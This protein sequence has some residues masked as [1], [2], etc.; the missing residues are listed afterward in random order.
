MSNV[1]EVIV[2]IEVILVCIG[3]VVFV[4][5]YMT[6][7]N[8][9]KT[10]AG[11]SLLYFV[12][13]LLSLVS[14]SMIRVLLSNE[15]PLF[16]ISRGLVYT[17]LLFTTW[18][19]VKVL[20]TSYKTKASIGYP[21][22]IPKNSKENILAEHELEG[23]HTAHVEKIWYQGQRVIRSILVAAPTTL[24][25][26]NLSLP[27]LASAFNSPDVPAEVYVLVN[28]IVLGMLAIIGILTKIIAIPAVN[29]WLTKLGAGS[30]PKS[31][32]ISLK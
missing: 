7:F 10:S 23:Q 29:A 12:I 16:F 1:V 31:T 2:D 18:Y 14:V 22:V 17:S 32:V 20:W 8:W 15:H 28:G 3:L 5:S 9:S 19:M 4:F 24:V 27:L 13:S 6:F 26:L 30:V 11:R 25:T 21:P